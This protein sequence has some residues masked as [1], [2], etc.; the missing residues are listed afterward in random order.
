[1]GE[2]DHLGIVVTKYSRSEPIKPK[3]VTKRSYKKFDVEKFLTDILN[4][5]IDKDVTACT[6][7][8][9][10]S[11]VFEQ[12][13]KDILDK[14]APIK[15]FQMRKHYSPYVSDNTKRLMEER[16]N[17][18]KEA[19]AEGNKV[20]EKEFKKKG[21]EIKKALINDEKLYYQKDFGESKDVSAAWR[22]AKVILG[23][24]NNLAP[25]VIKNTTEN[26]EVEMVTNPKRLANIFNN[27]FRKKIKLLR[28]KTNHPPATPP[29]E[30]L[31]KWLAK[32][33]DPPPPFKLKTIDKIMFRKIMSKVKPKRVQGVDQIDSYSLKLASL[34]IEEALKR[35]L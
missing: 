30:R 17:L 19:V 11:K 23:E 1:M 6:N 27:Y 32:R 28:E 35:I 10:A 7:V 25:T 20:A 24:N 16:N 29:C 12:S 4:S 34:L 13:F 22:T 8:E 26:G 14:H 3:T 18:K 5:T 33:G 2:S 15:T 9:E 21:K 31:K